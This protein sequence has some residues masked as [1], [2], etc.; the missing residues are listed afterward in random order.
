MQGGKGASYVKFSI[1]ELYPNESQGVLIYVDDNKV[2]EFSGWS[3]KEGDLTNVFYYRI[4]FSKI[5]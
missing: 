2:R 5:E 4:I 1:E 3:E